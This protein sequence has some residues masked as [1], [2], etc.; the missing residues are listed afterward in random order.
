MSDSDRR[1][2]MRLKKIGKATMILGFILAISD[3]P[4]LWPPFQDD[5]AL[6]ALIAG[7]ILAL[8]GFVVYRLP[9]ATGA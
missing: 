3:G 7:L 5:L 4:K 9:K 2:L 6:T 8:A 1:R